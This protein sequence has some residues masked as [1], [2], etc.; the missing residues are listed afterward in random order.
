M[1]KGEGKGWA[2]GRTAANDARIAHNATGRRGLIYQSRLPPGTDSRMK[3]ER[4]L[5]LVWSDGMAYVVGLTATDGCLYTGLRKINFKSADRDLVAT[6]L[7]VLGRTNTI[8]TKPTRTGGVVHFTEFGD[9]RFYRW[10]LSIGLTPRK[11]LTLGGIDAPDEFLAPLMRGLFEGDGNLQNFVHHPTPSTYPDYAYERLWLYFNS[12]SRAHVD[13]LQARARTAFSVH[14][15]VETRP[16]DETRHAFY[17]LKFGKRDSIT[18]LRAMYP[19]TNVPMLRRKWV[20][21]DDYR[22]RN[23]L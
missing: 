22:N 12:A 5:P 11:S 21:W 15:Y 9:A 8:K 14:G 1:A 16:A 23:G 3:Y 6:Y 17:R 13:W 18:L 19:D 20:V 10:L 2:K 7:V 4:R